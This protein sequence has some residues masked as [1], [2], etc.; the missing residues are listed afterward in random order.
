MRATDGAEN[1]SAPVTS[2]GIT[3]DSSNPMVSDVYEGAIGQDMDYQQDGTA[4]IVSWTGARDITSFRATLGSSAG[5]SNVVAWVDVGNVTNHTFSGLNLV[6]ATT[7][8]ASVQAED[9]AGNLSDIISGD[10]ITIDQS[11]PVPG[12]LNDGTAEDIDWVNINYLSVGNWT[13]FTDSLSGIAEYEFSVGLAPGQTQTVTWTSANLDTAI[14][15]SAS[16]TEGPTY[17]ANVR[18]VDSV[19]NVGDLV[20]SDGFG[21]DVSVPVTGNV[22]DGLADDLFWT[23]DST[24]LTANWVGFSDEFSGIAYYEYAIGTNSGGEDVVPWTMN[25]DSTFVIS[26]NLTL[27]SG[28][29]YYVSVRA[30]DWMNNISGTTTSNG[31]TLDTSNPVVT[32]PNEGG[33]GVDY[34]FQ[35]S[36][37]DI[38]ISWTGSDGTRSLSN[39]EYAI[40]LTEGGTE[41]TLWT[42]NGT[43]TDVTVTGLALTEG[44]TYYASVRA[45][46]MAGNVSAETTGDGITP[47]VTAPLTGMVMDGLQEELTYTGTLDSLSANWTGFSDNLSGI[48]FYEF[49]IGVSPGDSSVVAWSN[50]AQDTFYVQPVSVSDAQLY[51]VS[52][53]ATDNVTNRSEIVSSDGVTTDTTA[54]VMG[55]VFDGTQDSEIDWTNS[56][57]SLQYT[58]DGFNDAVSGIA[59]YQL[60]MGTT[61]GGTNIIP[62][63]MND[64]STNVQLYNLELDN[65]TEYFLNVRA[66][67]LVSNI[68]QV[69]STDGITTD[70]IPPGVQSIFEGESNT[71]WDYQ[72]NDTSLVLGWDGSDDASG[73]DHYEIAYGSAPGETDIVDW[74]FAGMEIDTNIIG[75]VLTEGFA[76]YGLVRAYDVAGNLSAVTAGDGI[77]VDL[78]PPEL[79]TIIDGDV[80]DKDYTGSLTTLESMWS[81][82]YD[83]LSGIQYY[84]YSVGTTPGD[85][86]F[87]DWTVANLDTV[88]ADESFDLSNG[89]SYFVSIR[90]TDNV[91]NVSVPI[92]TDGITADHEGPFGSLAADGDSAD[93][94]RQNFTDVY[95]GHWSAF[96]DQLSGLAFYEVA[97]YDSTTASYAIPWDSL[98][99]DTLVEFMDLTLIQDHEYKLHIRGVDHVQ[100]TGSIIASDGVLIDQTAPQ[101]PQS[102]VGFFSSERIYLTWDANTESDLDHYIVYGGLDT[103]QP[104]TILPTGDTEAEAFLPEFSNDEDVFLHI[105]ATDIPGN[106]SPKSNWVQGI[107]QPAMVTRILPDTSITILKDDNTFSIHFSQPLTDIGTVTT[108]SLAY[109]SM[110][111]EATYSPEDTSIKIT[112]NDPW[113]SMDTVTFAI[114]N[115]LD[116]AGSGTDEKTATFTTY[117]LGDY[118]NDFSVD[119]ADLSS[120]VTA[121]NNDDY[122]YELGPVTGTAPHFIPSRNQAYDLRDIMVFTRMWH[123]SHQTSTNRLLVYDPL[124]SELNI[125]QEGHRLV[126]DLP[127]ETN[128]AH[129]SLAYPQ[130]SKTIT[131]PEDINSSAVI[132]LV[133][134]PEE[135]GQIIIEKAFMKRESVKN[136]SFD[137]NSLDRD[138]AV[139]E[140]NYIAYDDS[141]R[142][143]ASGRQTLDIIAIPDQFALHQNYPNPFNPTTTINYDVPEDGF[144]EIIIYDLM[145]REVKTLMKNELS[146]GYYTLNWGGKNNRGQIVGAGLYFCQLRARGFTKTVKMLLL[147]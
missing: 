98:G 38:I 84:E 145:G 7:Y 73:I 143:I 131:T 83:V 144:A 93:I 60:S 33:V 147:K 9:L 140:I 114:N 86:D 117:L 70:T 75:L 85:T 26:I 6:E 57:E 79:G 141:N 44:I 63:T 4:L 67:D 111:L 121:W 11:G 31:I 119:V 66:V 34:D 137:I 103:L 8:Y 24:T 136:V 36:L 92:S 46:D 32:V 95:T 132:Q 130:A 123:Y 3:I 64:D 37:S 23:A 74:L 104:I 45:I 94:D 42:D 97:L 120:F 62:W 133:Y 39:Y 105:T 127:A 18:A 43:S 49:A 17:Y 69:S 134:Q 5:D 47:D 55:S 139:I 90:A 56:L 91:G 59:H 71:D 87:K 113:A 116:W 102:L 125:Y 77:V 109:S 58:W 25:G 142:V 10:G 50:V 101:A 20:S 48:L 13:G 2:D 35:N 53:R 52:I 22:Y 51:F 68:S 100:N 81:G 88:I 80:S 61:T 135:S 122:S 14:T 12:Q 146:A 118:N 54:P 27:E 16:L 21:L 138:N 129:V 106:E 40:G 28:T 15:V 126:V 41:T 1:V 89:Q 110:N 115:I 72:N 124:G 82:F 128:A 96:E 29:T 30:T 112:V 19:L 107:P 76:Y 65:G 108:T 99:L 78:T